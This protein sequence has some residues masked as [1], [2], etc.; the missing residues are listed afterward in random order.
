MNRG[1]PFDVAIAGE[2]PAA[3]VMALTLI[4]A[5]ARVALFGEFREKGTRSGHGEC[6]P[7]AGTTWLRHLGLEEHLRS[8]SLLPIVAQRSCW[9]SEQIETSEL[10]QS[11]HGTAWILDRSE[12]DQWLLQ[13]A[14]ERGAARLAQRRG[15]IARTDGQWNFETTEG[16]AHARYLVDATGR[17]ASV[18]H[19][20][21]ARTECHDRLVALAFRAST[22]ATTDRDA[23]TY[24]ESAPDGWWYSCR[25]GPRE[26]LV[27]YF[28]DADLLARTSAGRRNDF[29]DRLERTGPLKKTL[30]THDYQLR[31][32][33]ETAIARNSHLHPLCGDGWLAVGDA[34]IGH[35]PLGGHGILAAMDSARWAAHSLVEAARGRS[36]AFA[37]YASFLEERHR[38]YRRHLSRLYSAEERWSSRPFWMRRTVRRWGR[39]VHRRQ[40]VGYRPLHRR[41]VRQLDDQ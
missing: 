22:I 35:D 19:G 17:R 14:V 34:A 5:G 7:P 39:G 3:S 41:Q 32:E 4:E 16:S 12:F 18:A 21:G 1:Q 23:T 38:A 33:W 37:T 36:E 31:D 29:R 13:A 11:A 10:I 2:G 30:A 25:T 20:L 28:T 15:P 26:R 6:L 9:G 24:I 27:A 40:Q 8:P